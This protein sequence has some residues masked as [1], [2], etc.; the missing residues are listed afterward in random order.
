MCGVVWRVGDTGGW[1][2]RCWAV[3]VADRMR[4]VR[5]DAIMGLIAA[6]VFSIIGMPIGALRGGITKVLLL[7]GACSSTVTLN[8]GL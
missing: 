3:V 6:A 1:F 8:P 4:R 2:H 7:D 5:N